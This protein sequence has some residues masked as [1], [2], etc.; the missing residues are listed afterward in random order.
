MSDYQNLPMVRLKSA[1]LSS[2]P[3][4]KARPIDDSTR[5]SPQGQRLET[6]SSLKAPHTPS[7]R[8]SSSLEVPKPVIE[9]ASPTIAADTNGAIPSAARRSLVSPSRGSGSP[10]PPVAKTARKPVLDSAPA[11]NM[12]GPPIT[13][14]GL[15]TAGTLPNF[16]LKA[17]GS[18][19][20]TPASSRFTTPQDTL[21]QP[22]SPT[23]HG[24]S[25]MF[26]NMMP[27]AG[28]S[29]ASLTT[30]IQPL[31][32]PPFYASGSEPA[33]H[34]QARTRH[35]IPSSHIVRNPPQTS[36]SQSQSGS[37]DSR[38]RAA[39]IK[40]EGQSMTSLSLR[41]DAS[42][43]RPAKRLKTNGPAPVSPSQ[44]A[45]ATA[46]IHTG[47]AV[48]DSTSSSEPASAP[49]TNARQPSDTKPVLLVV[50]VLKPLLSTPPSLAPKILPD[51][52]HRHPEFW[53]MDGSIVLQAENILFKLHRSRLI[54]HSPLFAAVLSA[55]KKNNNDVEFN[56]TDIIAGNGEFLDGC[57]IFKL[58]HVLAR[59]FENLLRALER[60][61]DFVVKPPPFP[62]V[63]SILRTAH[64]LSFA[65]ISQ[66]ATHVLENMWPNDIA[67]LS[68]KPKLHAA[69]AILLAQ[70]CRV[71][72]LKHAYYD[73]LRTRAFGASIPTVNDDMYLDQSPRSDTSPKAQFLCSDQL[74]LMVVVRERLQSEWIHIMRGP[75]K[76]S[77]CALERR[78]PTERERVDG[79]RQQLE[80]CKTATSKMA[81]DW[82][83]LLAKTRVYEI[84]LFDILGG[85][86][87]LL[88]EK[89]RGAGFCRGC[90]EARK[91][92]WTDKKRQIWDNLDDWLGL[93]S[94]DNT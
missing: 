91:Q 32:L 86:D 50:P 79:M 29:N 82:S 78:P 55:E 77:A 94:A 33:R 45:R 9:R 62:V 27:R 47:V 58:M 46:P 59:D 6:Q 72:V 48:P 30:N 74:V 14:R 56:S 66:F 44:S 90:V 39:F 42:S 18:A 7:G 69:E 38:K 65:S 43:E 76:L 93:S 53:H 17:A 4:V 20:S 63:A 52:R 68:T 3:G 26:S 22:A 51:P 88:N 25:N 40:D 10:K 5:L 61:Y 67:R 75:P 13:P 28:S 92:I 34:E 87:L 8:T 21:F 89:W 70:E 80:R 2:L 19:V 16:K 31:C 64:S 73:L 85:L 60:G 23:I 41:A 83:M 84:G 36:A 57:A 81:Q 12:I 1:S 49:V 71:S 37:T 54:Q 24:L 35:P 11:K 15:T